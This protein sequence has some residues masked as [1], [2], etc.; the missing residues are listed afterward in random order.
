MRRASWLLALVGLVLSACY[1]VSPAVVEQGVAAPGWRDGLYGRD[2]GTQVDLRWDGERSAYVVGA[3]GMVRLARLD[4]G[5]Y[6]AD[7][8]AE[9]RIVLLAR[10]DGNG[11]LVFLAPSEASERRSVA[12]FGLQ[13]RSGPIP[14]LDGSAEAIRRYFAELAR[15]GAAAELV[16]AGRLRWLHS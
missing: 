9:R 1:Q 3:G 12:A 14:R 11:D 10:L 5:L 13:V 15:Q 6:L 8:Q 16:E 2:D 4:N 7:Y